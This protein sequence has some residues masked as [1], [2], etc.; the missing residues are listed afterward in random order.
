MVL[1]LLLLFYFCL[2]LS[3]PHHKTLLSSIPFLSHS[4]Q[5]FQI[6]IWFFIL[7]NFHSEN[8][9]KIRNWINERTNK[10]KYIEKENEKVLKLFVWSFLFNFFNV[11]FLS[12]YCSQNAFSLTQSGY[13]RVKLNNE[14]YN[15][16]ILFFFFCKKTL[17]L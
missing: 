7:F 10:R 6:I 16:E 14:K 12:T 17:L 15:E 13:L 1:R 9:V 4:T 2:T 11:H 8:K 3:Y 5:K